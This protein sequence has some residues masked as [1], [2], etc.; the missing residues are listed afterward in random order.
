MHQKLVWVLVILVTIAKQHG[1]SQEEDITNSMMDQ[2]CAAAQVLA[3][4]TNVVQ[5]K[6][7]EAQ[8]HITG[9][10]QARALAMAAAFQKTAPKLRKAAGPVLLALSKQ[11][12]ALNIFLKEASELTSTATKMLANLSGQQAALALF[13]D[14]KVKDSTT[15]QNDVD[16]ATS[17][18]AN[19]QFEATTPDKIKACHA[20]VNKQ[21]GKFSRWTTT[22]GFKSI[23]LFTTSINLNAAGKD[24]KPSLGKNSARTCTHG[25]LTGCPAASSNICVIGGKIT[26]EAGTSIEATPSNNFGVNALGA[27]KEDNQEHYNKIALLAAFTAIKKWEDKP[28]DFDINNADSYAAD[29]DFTAAV[30]AVYHGLTREASLGTGKNA[31]Q[32]TIRNEYGKGK[33]FKDKFWE[34]VKKAPLPATVLGE[35]TNGKLES[36]TTI[37]AAAKLILQKII[38]EN[39]KPVA[40]KETDNEAKPI[41]E[42]KA[43]KTPDECKKHTSEKSCKEGGC[44]FDEKKDPKCFPKAE[45]DKKDEKSFSR[46]LR[47]YFYKVFVALIFI[48]F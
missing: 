21:A 42:D 25:T 31:I 3:A 47:V 13:K 48:L 46:N 30:G 45:T 36:V 1:S 43:S 33:E 35:K 12:E 6:P 8:Q 39:K 29:P 20:K 19:I 11:T 7:K 5:S 34:E 17:G 26:A 38:D 37:T 10:E 16:D 41:K 24:A 27:I 32:D 15:S 2:A 9:L 14:L 23:K 40:S 4:I 44:D 22:A 28:Q 18:A